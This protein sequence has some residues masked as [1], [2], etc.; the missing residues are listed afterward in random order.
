MVNSS[1]GSLL[2]SQP[3]R[4]FFGGF[5]SGLDTTSI[6]DA[7]TLVQRRPIELALQRV[8]AIQNRQGALST[9]NSSLANLLSS[10]DPLRQTDTVTARLASLPTADD[11]SKLGVSASSSA[12]IGS[13]T[14]DIDALASASK[15]TGTGALGQAVSQVLALDEAGFGIA[16]TAG[17]FTIDSTTFTIPAPTFT[18]LASN[19]TIGDTDNTAILNVAGL[20]IPPAASGTFDI[21]GITITF[22]S[23][24]DTLDAIMSRINASSAGVAATFDP[25]TDL[26]TL[27]RTA[28]GP[29]LITVSDTTGNFLEAMNVVDAVNLKIGTEIAGTDMISLTDVVSMINLAAIGVTATVVNDSDGR[30]NLLQLSSASAITVGAGGD[31]S[32]FLAATH[33][34]ESP[35]GTTRTSVRNIGV[36]S[37]SSTL[38]TARLDVAPAPA[39]GTFEVNGVEITY[40]TA[41]D[42]IN[43]I[44]S[45]LNESAANVTATYDAYSDRLVVTSDATG[46]IPITLAD[47]SG[48]F[49]ASMK[50]L[51]ATQTLGANAQ[52]RINGGATQYATTNDVADAIPGVS[53]TLK[54]TTATAIT[55]NVAADV[56]SIR[57]KVLAFVDQFN[58]TMGLITDSTKFVEDGTN[59]S[60]LGDLTL[61]TIENSMRSKITGPVIGNTS[62]LNT[63]A[64]IGLTFGAVGSAAG[65]ANVLILDAAKFDAAVTT[66]PEGVSRLLSAFIASA[67]LD[68]PNSTGSLATVTGTPTVVKDSGTYTLTSS[69][70]G[71]L[72]MT[73]TPDNGDV[74][75]VTTHTISPGEVNTAL[76]PGLT[77]TFQNPL[78][79]GTDSIVVTATEE[80]VGKG[81]YE[82]LNTFTRSGGVMDGRDAEMQARIDDINEQVERMEL[83]VEGR[84]QALI[85]KYARFEVTMAQLQSQQAALTNFVNQANANKK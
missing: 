75:I 65:D 33:L 47:T 74:A 7:L 60:L 18:T 10:L 81:L 1:S 64:T 13:F 23:T 36:V 41:T 54:Q 3:E 84:R 34:L 11:F 85:Q 25:A 80:G 16:P 51:A 63:L 37:T 29:A 8:S 83:R 68:V 69:V 76:I 79:D 71:S 66:N 15:T 35:G 42:S 12:A 56:S 62:A 20:T 22:D 40:D 78:V 38:A 17:T 21:N 19:A 48:N 58:S 55:V 45:R 67:A 53:L 72:T 61:R 5:A 43:S 26:F 50:V 24:V 30:P 9:I 2:G 73:F 44:I 6:I 82:Y 57:G 14:V 27:T 31:T 59:G 52:Y 28:D 46:S 77:L 4:L 39:T 32:N 49:L 70:S